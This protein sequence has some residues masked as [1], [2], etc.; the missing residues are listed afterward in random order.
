VTDV[1]A[2]QLASK[3]VEVLYDLAGVAAGGATV[4]VR[5]STDG[6][7]TWSVVP[8]ASALSGHVGAGV[9][10]GS[11]RRIVWE[12]AATLPEGFVSSQVKAA[13]TAVDPGRR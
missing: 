7:S 1:R 3:Q 8:A 11:D 5:F 13:V 9:L 6:G 10:A 2:E 12:A 4:S